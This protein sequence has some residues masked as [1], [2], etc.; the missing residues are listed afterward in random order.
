MLVSGIVII[1]MATVYSAAVTCL[2]L[3]GGLRDDDY[4]VQGSL[5]LGGHG[6]PPNHF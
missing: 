4:L 5:Q 3:R 1:R 6:G 2:V